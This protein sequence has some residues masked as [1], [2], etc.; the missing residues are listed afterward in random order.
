MANPSGIRAGQAFVELFADDS[1]LVRGLNAASKKL[2]DWGQS[3]TAAG[4]KMLTT[5]MAAVGGMFGATSVFATMGDTLEKASQRTGI[6]VERLSELAYAAEQ[7]GADLATLEAGV[8]RM[9]KTIAEAAG[10]SES[11]LEAL[12]NLGLSVQQLAGLSPDQQFT[13][14]ADRLAQ[15]ADPA[16]RAAAAMKVFGQAGTQLLPMVADGAAGIEALSQ[17]ARDLGLVMSTEDAQAAVVF[18]D[19]VSDLWKTVKMGVFVIG[20]ALAPILSDLTER[21]MGVITSVSDWIK[22]NKDVVVTVFKVA[23]AVAV[24]G[25]A[26]IVLGG[27]LSGLGFA[28]GTLASIATGVGTVLGVIGTVLGAIL[29]PVGLVIAALASL[30]GYLIY[31]SGVGGKALRWLGDQFNVL[32]EWAIATWQGI[33]DAIAAGDLQLAVK[34]AWLAIKLQWQ[35][36]ISA[37]M[38]WWRNFTGFFSDFAVNAFYT[39]A[40][41]A[42]WLWYTMKKGGNEA[43]AFICD[44]FLTAVQFLAQVWRNLAIML[45]KG[46]MTVTG[47]LNLLTEA[48]VDQLASILE[49]VGVSIDETLEQK[50]GEVEERRKDWSKQIEEQQ[51]GTLGVLEDERTKRLKKNAEAREKAREEELKGIEQTE[52]EWR[53]ALAEAARLREQRAA[54][55]IPERKFPEAPPEEYEMP[56]LEFEGVAQ[57]SISVVGTFNPLAA[58]GLGTGGPLERTARASEET[59]K[60][61]KK[62]VQQAQHGGLVFT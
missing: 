7:S 57:R 23:A 40:E 44:S 10:G 48:L 15:I 18:G 1:R 49:K 19:L 9:Q 22:Q 11:A 55:Q 25:A 42:A 38:T 34:I 6:T 51:T 61:T 45:I 17:R 36:G 46:W 24:G 62:L 3:V 52:K 28:F 47:T 14:I 2:K 20:A 56:T 50:R 32:K 16:Q 39:A 33:A 21:V 53:E 8:R 54:E 59:A 41:T 31:T 5:G 27:I 29:S 12:V 37:L 35:R 4:Q 13:L 58:A 26:L 30:A 43:L 60:N